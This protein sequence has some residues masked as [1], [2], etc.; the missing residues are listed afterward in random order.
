[1]SSG[2][3]Q[4]IDPKPMDQNPEQSDHQHDDQNDQQLE[5]AVGGQGT[6]TIKR[7]PIKPEFT[8]SFS[9]D[10]DHPIE[11]RRQEPPKRSSAVLR[12]SITM[13][14]NRSAYLDNLLSEI[15]I[16]EIN[17]V[18]VGDLDSHQ[19]LA[20]QQW[21]EFSVYHEKLCS[22]A[23]EELLINPYFTED[24]FGLTLTAYSDISKNLGRLRTIIEKRDTP[25]DP[26]S[27]ANHPSAFNS[28]NSLKR[29]D[30][31]E[32]QAFSGKYSEW[33]PF[34]DLFQSL[35]GEKKF[36]SPI[37][38]L[39]R[40]K[41]AL[42]GPA[43]ALISNLAT[44]SEN[45][46]VAWKTLTE[47]YE[48]RR[49]IIAAHLNR[50]L[51]IEHL[52]KKSAQ[53]LTNIVDTTTKA[54]DALKALG[55]PTEHWDIIITHLIR[56]AIDTDTREAWE[57][58]L[59][60]QTDPPLLSEFIEFLRARARALENVEREEHNRGSQPTKKSQPSSST[61]Q[62]KSSK[63][64]QQATSLH[65][66]TSGQSTGK[67][68][69][70]PA[71]KG[72]APTKAKSCTF[73]GKDHWAGAG[74]P[75]FCSMKPQERKEQVIKLDL[76]FNCLGPHRVHKCISDKR[77]LVCQERHHT[78]IHETY[79]SSNKSSISTVDEQSKSKQDTPS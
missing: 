10:D 76:C 54:L 53:G 2:D 38:K 46:E 29:I 43:A 35:I 59:G 32:D 40:L 21:R 42:R 60:S 8:G 74:C 58:K 9:S 23:T 20:D 47:R 65:Q 78:M 57:V 7:K 33:K 12:A 70:R 3:E 69:P 6:G 41:S 26:T 16:L 45:Y 44:T 5:G 15:S 51:N 27:T 71:C 4:E 64:Q 14:M 28:T 19:K 37:E 63:P 31:T 79:V 24:Y 22:Q 48:N 75:T 39:V 17:K 73:C 77:C 56:C 50:I 36:I 1:M 30:I 13:Q 68:I 25:T 72:K 67:Q 52:N 62:T 18:G 61:S 66:S 34:A 55:A 11:D 49:L